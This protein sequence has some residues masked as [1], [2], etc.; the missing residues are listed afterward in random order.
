MCFWRGVW[1]GVGPEPRGRVVGS[2]GA[3]KFKDRHAGPLIVE[4]GCLCLLLAVLPGTGQESGDEVGT[5]T[6]RVRLSHL[7]SCR[8]LAAR[9]HASTRSLTHKCSCFQWR[10]GR[11][12]SRVCLGVVLTALVLN[13]PDRG[14][15]HPRRLGPALS[16]ASRH[17]SPCSAKQ[18]LP[19]VGAT[20]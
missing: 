17:R 13:D 1:G 7:Q 8:P 12:K 9:A 4:V 16:G 6:G 11:A 19:A 14:Q 3:H 10:C 15:S 5:G 18:Q 20:G 2:G